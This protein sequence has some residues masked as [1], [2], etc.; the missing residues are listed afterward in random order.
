[1]YTP[2]S[3]WAVHGRSI[4]VNI[5][6]EEQVDTE[7]SMEAGKLPGVCWA[8]EWAMKKVKK[9][10][11]SNTTVAKIKSK[12]LNICN[13]IGLLKKLCHKFVKRHLSVLLEEL[14]TTDDVRTICVNAKACK[15]YQTTDVLLRPKEFSDL[16]SHPDDKDTEVVIRVYPRHRMQ[17]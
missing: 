6:D 2:P 5:D 1:M 7:I 4:T 10:I 13:E 17:G 12:L 16:V 8:C 14:T 15:R 3:V 11:G 9:G